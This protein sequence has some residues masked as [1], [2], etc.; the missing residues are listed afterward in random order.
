MAALAAILFYAARAY[1]DTADDYVS[2][3]DE[4][5][6]DESD[7]YY[8]VNDETADMLQMPADMAPSAELETMLKKGEALRLTPYQLGDGGWSLGYGRYF[9]FNGPP[10]PASISQATADAWFDEDIEARAAQWVRAYVTTPLTQYQFDA[11][12]SMAY[13]LKPTSFATIAAAVNNGNDPETASLQYVRAGTN[14]EHG[15]RVRRAREVALYRSGLY[16]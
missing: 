7:P 13:N 9:P 10:P 12:C 5:T 2:P 6:G 1:A 3:D 16:S 14:L 8:S 4:Y 11:L 15:L